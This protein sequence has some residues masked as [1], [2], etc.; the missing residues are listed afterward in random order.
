[1]VVPAV[2]K[3]NVAMSDGAAV[4]VGI[5]LN[6]PSVE[7]PT[8]NV[9]KDGSTRPSRALISTPYMGASCLSARSG[10]VTKS[11]DNFFVSRS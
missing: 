5:G 6:V 8:G 1:M 3:V 2:V 4:V 7:A 11:L 9:T 10:R